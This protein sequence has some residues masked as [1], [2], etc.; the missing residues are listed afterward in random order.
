MAMVEERGIV[1]RTVD[2]VLY[3][4]LTLLGLACLLPFLNV[5][6]ISLSG[7]TAVS[8]KA[9]WFWPIS[10]NLDNYGYIL[11]DD[12]FIRSFGISVLRVLVGVSL[13]LLVMVITA[14]PLSRDN[15]YMPGRTVFKALMLF[16]MMFG[17]GLIPY[18]LSLSNL[19]LLNKFAVLV[20]PTA[21]NIFNT[22]LI[23]NFFR[24]IPPELYESAVLDGANHLQ[25]LFRIFLPIS[26]PVLA[27]VTLFS[28]VG[29]WNSWFDGLIYLK[30][31]SQWPLQSYLYT[32]V[33]TRMLQ[34]NVS[35][36]A[37]RAGATFQQATPEG[38][39]AAMIIIATIPIILVYPA[40]QRYFVT[41]LTLGAV[42]Q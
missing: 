38:L 5:I 30:D 11:A 26:T 22:I 37:D 33:T 18:F 2:I 20:I 42:K 31:S 15:I 3:A 34:W 16:G 41:G 8:A 9:V 39:Q 12:V 21:L 24:G 10:F 13:S 19:G 28:S 27:T 6:A 4:I 17:G 32:R 35:G 40:L 1:D 36:S 23:I 25:V 7:F 29:H 14:Y